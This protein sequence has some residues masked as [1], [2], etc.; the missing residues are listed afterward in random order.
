M[1][2]AEILETLHAAGAE[3]SVFA[4]T[5]SLIG[6]PNYEIELLQRGDTGVHTGPDVGSLG[7]GT[8]ATAGGGLLYTNRMSV[9]MET[10]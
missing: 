5:R 10:C 6:F 9:N 8:R 2:D 4:W 1:H 7:P 3:C